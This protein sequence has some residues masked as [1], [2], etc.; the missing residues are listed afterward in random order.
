M[1]YDFDD[2]FDEI[3]Y[4]EID[5]TVDIEYS[6]LNKIERDKKKIRNKNK[7]LNANKQILNKIENKE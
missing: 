3:E 5:T 4:I 7:R 2:C 1:N 6:V